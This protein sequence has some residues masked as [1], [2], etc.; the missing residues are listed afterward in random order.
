MRSPR[1]IIADFISTLKK[2][3]PRDTKLIVKDHE[4]ELSYGSH[5]CSIHFFKTQPNK[6]HI[7]LQIALDLAVTRKQKLIG[8]IQ[9]KLHYTRIVFARD[10]NV[11]RIAQHT[12]NNF[13]EEFHLMGHTKAAFCYGLYDTG[14]LIAVATFSK[15]RKMNRLDEQ[16]R[17][18][19]MIRFC[20][21]EGIT[22]SGG[23]SKLLSHFIK[24]KEPG[25]IMTYV[26]KQYSDGRSYYT[27]GFKKHSETEAHAFLIEKDT[28]KRTYYN[29]VAIDKT[30]YYLAY[31]SGNIKLVNNLEQQRI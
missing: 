31:N 28:L 13:L 4:A 1:S 25:D 7:G 9:S 6:D 3:L 15:G 5:H 27:C 30:R 21:K 14:E 24:E 18:F 11:K 19:E 22:V 26:D 12:A 17:S 2:E 16:Q 23:L 20:C 10:C 29:G 8:I